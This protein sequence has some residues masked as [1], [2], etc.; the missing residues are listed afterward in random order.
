MVH[1]DTESISGLH[2]GAKLSFL[3]I[4][5]FIVAIYGRPEDIFPSIGALHLTFLLGLS[6]GASFLWALFQGDV[7]LTWPLELR[8]VLLLTVWFAAG[9][10]FAYWRGGSFTVLTQIWL[11]T[12]LIFFLL[13]QTLVTL[14]RIRCVLWAIILSELAVTAY[15]LAAP[16]QL[17]WKTCLG[18]DA[19][20]AGERM[21]GVSQGF[22]YWN[23]LGIAL[24]MIIPY[25]AALFISK[26]ST[27]RSALLAATIASMSWM[28]VLTA[29]RSGTL[30]VA[31]SVLLTSFVVA[32]GNPRGK[33]V[34]AGTIL[35]LI[36]T[37]YMAPPVFWQRIATII[38]ADSAPV[39]TVQGSAD[40]SKEERFTLLMRSVTYT[41][42]HPVFGLG[43]GNF[44]VANGND[45]DVPDA[46]IGSHNTY[47]QISS[48]AGVPALLLFL[49]LLGTVL[50]SMKR[51]MWLPV[52]DLSSKELNLMAR[53]TF[54][55]LLAFMLGAFFAHKG[56]DYYVYAGPIAIAAGIHRIAANSQ[57]I[58]D[59]MDRNLVSQSQYLNPGWTL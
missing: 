52:E 58:V 34:R 23:A 53:A 33:I 44:D 37:I 26:R 40:Q 3:F 55:S 32:R 20:S 50:R 39:D 47:T 22:L 21:V 57:A 11:K 56:Y 27:P 54:V 48:E 45:L 29:S 4:C 5:L 30:V 46:W 10:P 49:V 28:Q 16:S 51:V 41:L 7:S 9:V 35:A 12:A 13:T 25:I 1:Q 36:V 38:D 2:P 31:F 59:R 6:A 18:C 8:I 19:G 17:T 42:E 24:G 14:K 43:L 15:S